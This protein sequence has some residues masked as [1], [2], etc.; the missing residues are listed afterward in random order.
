MGLRYQET[1][2]VPFDMVDVKQEL[3]IPSFLAYC[4]ALSGRQSELLGRGDK[5]IFEQYGLVWVVTDY[6]VE[7]TCLPHYQETITIE[8]EAIS[9][10]KFFCYRTFHIYDTVGNLL[11]KIL[12][13]FVLIDFETRKI[14]P[15]PE[16]LI[17]P[18][19]AER[20]KKVARAS[21][22]GTMEE[23]A[24]HVREVRYFD[25][26]LNGHVNNSKYLE[27][28]YE[29]LDYDFLATHRPSYFQIKYIKEVAPETVV[30]TKVVQ[31]EECSQHEIWS[32]GQL[33]AQGM[34]KWG[35]NDGSRS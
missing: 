35:R 15:V 17:A 13:H 27:W 14:S 6:E 9:Y 10:N 4:L 8:T 33:K 30:M 25:I 28:M 1:F 34:I 11:I 2:T 21:K 26:D 20:V 32:G 29:S 7:L 18:Y 19:Q 31:E 5:D 24:E 16:E 12:A 22:Y 23:A 3:K